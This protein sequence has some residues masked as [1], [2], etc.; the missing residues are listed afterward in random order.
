VDV[1]GLGGGSG[2]LDS[3]GLIV[4]TGA[5]RPRLETLA[6]LGGPND[7]A[8]PGHPFDGT[9][10]PVNRE[11]GPDDGLQRFYVSIFSSSVSE[12]FLIFT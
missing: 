1:R 8:A 6:K 4:V 12:A 5:T 2:L 7:G 10:V 3:A 11:P 9:A